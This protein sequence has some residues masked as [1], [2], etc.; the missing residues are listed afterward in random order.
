MR[1]I[2]LA[3]LLLITRAF[4]AGIAAQAPTATKVES[5]VVATGEPGMRFIVSP[6]GAHMAVITQKG[7]RF[8]VLVDGVPGPLFDEM[9]QLDGTT[10]Q[11][12][13]SPD[14]K[15]YAYAFRSGA[16][17]VVIVDGKE[18]LRVPFSN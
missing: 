8:V 18:Q 2:P 10:S 7:S 15:R 16:E 9:V 6:R 1:T 11:V 14:G 5:Q 17:H 12:S 3:L 13:F 4:P